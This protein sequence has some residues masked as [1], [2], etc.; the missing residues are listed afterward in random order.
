[1]E[2][3]QELKYF[4]RIA[5][6]DLDGKKSIIQSLTGIKGVGFSFANA[7][8]GISGIDKKKKTGYLSDEEAKKIEEII[9]NPARHGIPA[10]LFNRRKDPEDSQDKHL[11]TST[12]AFVR[13]ND[14][15]LMKKIKSYKGMRHAY[16]LPVRGQKTR[17]NFRRNK[18]KVLG[19]KVRAGAKEGG[20]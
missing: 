5:N 14:V 12:L 8:C 20:K 16:G 11:L 9:N 2:E 7:V 4:I 13:D 19:V 10:W 17:S 1:M 6:N 15:K 18:G 3:K